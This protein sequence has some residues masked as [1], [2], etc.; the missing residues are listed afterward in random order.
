MNQESRKK[1]EKFLDEKMSVICRETKDISQILDMHY[2]KTAKGFDNNGI[3]WDDC[4]YNFF[5]NNNC[6]CLFYYASK[7][8]KRKQAIRI[9]IDKIS[10]RRWRGSIGMLYRCMDEMNEIAEEFRKLKGELEKQE[11]IEE[12]TKNS[13]YTWLNTIMKNQPYSYYIKESELKITLS[14]KL[15]YNTQLDIPIY[16]SNFQNIMPEVLET[17]QQFTE[18]AEKRKIKALISNSKPHEQWKWAGGENGSKH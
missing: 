16:Y 9:S 13:I 6:Q 15:K 1:L 5:N 12:L 3:N 7:D 8:G 14:V 11:K 2:V 18:N 10:S 4:G 17:I